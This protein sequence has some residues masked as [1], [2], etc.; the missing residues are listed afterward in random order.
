MDKKRDIHWAIEHLK[1]G[2]R[3]RLSAW[4]PG[5][6]VSLKWDRILTNEKEEGVNLAGL[7]FEHDWE[8]HHEAQGTQETFG[9]VE[10]MRRMETGK[11][12]SRVSA[13]VEGKPTWFMKGKLFEHT[14]T[15][16][17]VKADDWIEYDG[18]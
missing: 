8:L 1:T 7:L 9:F 16:D 18:C 11:K 2:S 6:Y 13:M 14:F 12:V 17:C 15:L 5:R 10:A 3:I 4:S